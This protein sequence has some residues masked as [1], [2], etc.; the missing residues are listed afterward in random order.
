MKKIAVLKIGLICILSLFLCGCAK[1]DVRTSVQ[2]ATWGSQSELE[3]LKPI[4]AE[5]EKENPTVRV[6]FMHIPQNY[7]QKI[8]LL[9][10]SNTPPDVIFVNNL[11]L[12]IYANAGVLEPLGRIDT[13][14]YDKRAL[15]SLSWQ[16]KLY[17]VP[18]DISNMVIFY[19]K[20]LF[21]KKSIP[22]PSGNWDFAEF[23]NTAKKLS[24]NGVWGISFEESPIYYLPYLMSEGGGILSD[25]LSKEIISDENSQRGLKFYADLRKKYHVAPKKEEIASATNAQLFLQQKLAMHLSGRWLVPKY[26]EEAKFDWDIINFPKGTKGSIVPMDASGWAIAKNSKHKAEAELLIKYLSSKESIE[27]FTKSG[28]IVPAR[29]DVAHSSAFLDGQKPQNAQVFLEVA[30]TSKPT[31]ISVNYQEITDNLS[32]YLEKVFN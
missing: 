13:K 25:D 19:N 29:L 5:F 30:R 10:A 14:I 2:F 1:K 23:L 27:K 20:D 32:K 16:G 24:G 12:P 22:L 21:R 31:P 6:D 18:R 26:R 9:F 28:L 4:L 7:L 8:H 11:Y 3:I 17:A 15:K